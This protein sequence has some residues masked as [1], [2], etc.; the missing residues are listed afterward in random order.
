MVVVKVSCFPTFF[1]ICTQFSFFF[2]FG[3]A[4]NSCGIHIS[5]VRRNGV[6]SPASKTSREISPV[7][8]TVPSKQTDTLSPFSVCQTF[9]QCL[10]CGRSYRQGNNFILMK[11]AWTDFVFIFNTGLHLLWTFGCWKVTLLI[12]SFMILEY[13]IFSRAEKKNNTRIIMSLL[14]CYT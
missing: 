12:Y 8:P 3:V 6:I 2:H 4:H 11:L 1:F 10:I 14:Y 9:H 7:L 5:H 13:K